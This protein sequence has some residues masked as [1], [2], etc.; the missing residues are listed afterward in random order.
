VNPATPAATSKFSVGLTGGIGSGKTSVANAFAR[1]GASIIDTDAIAHQL[2]APHAAAIAAIES[3]FGQELI[4]PEGALNRAKM[5]AIVFADQKQKTLLES[6]LHPMIRSEVSRLSALAEGP[7]IMYVVPL[8]AET[9]HW[10]FSR[11]LVVDCD[12][13]LQIQRVTQRNKLSADLIKSIIAQQAT[14][15]QRLAIANDVLLN[16]GTFETLIPEIDRLH[17]IYCQL[18]S[19]NQTEYL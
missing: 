15:Q 17:K 14:R 11:I 1:L 8:L 9:G 2:T 4:T 10:K 3:A 16:Q 7:Y 12:E 6:I 18:S 13:E 5:R 19:S